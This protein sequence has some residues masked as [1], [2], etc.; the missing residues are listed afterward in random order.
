MPVGRERF[1][2]A[3]AFTRVLLMNCLR[4]LLANPWASSDS[5]AVLGLSHPQCECFHAL[6]PHG[7]LGLAWKQNSQ[8]QL[9][10]C[11]CAKPTLSMRTSCG[12]QDFHVETKLNPYQGSS[13][14]GRI[15]DRTRSEVLWPAGCSTSVGPQDRRLQPQS[16]FRTGSLGAIAFAAERNLAVEVRQKRRQSPGHG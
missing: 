10:C 8:A 9:K 7:W 15:V 12:L 6:P 13:P 16:E 11:A 2:S 5:E 1:P 14:S 3:N 4:L